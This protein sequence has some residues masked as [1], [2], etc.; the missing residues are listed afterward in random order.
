MKKNISNLFSSTTFMRKIYAFIFLFV[1]A[2]TYIGAKKLYAVTQTQCTGNFPIEIGLNPNTSFSCGGLTISNFVVLNQL[3]EPVSMFITGAS[4]A[5]NKV[6]FTFD[7]VLNNAPFGTDYVFRYKVTG[8][9]SGLGVSMQGENSFIIADACSSE[10]DPVTNYITCTGDYRNRLTTGIGSTPDMPNHQDFYPGNITYYSPIYLF[11]DIAIANFSGTG[12]GTIS[13]FTE[14][15]DV[16]P[17]P[18]PTNKTVKVCLMLENSTGVLATTSAGLPAAAMVTQFATTQDTSL[19]FFISQWSTTQFTPNTSILSNGVN[20]AECVT[21]DRADIDPT[22]YYSPLTIT[23]SGWGTPLYND[24]L[25]SSLNS[26]Q[27]FFPYN[28]DYTNNTYPISNSNG[29]IN[30]SLTNDTRTVVYF[31]PRATT[32]P[33]PVNTPPTITLVGDNPQQFTIGGNFTDLGA[34]AT[35]AQDGNLTSVIIVTSNNVS[36][37]TPGTY[38]ITYRVTDSGGLSAEVTRTVIVSNPTG[39][40][41]SSTG[42]IT[43]CL[44]IGDNQ[45]N[46]ATTSTGLPAGV[47]YVNLGTTTALS[48]SSL[49][50]VTN[51]PAWSAST[52]VPNTKT[53]GNINDSQCFTIPNLSLGT[54]YYSQLYID[55]PVWNTAKLS[56]G[57]N[58]T[59]NNI[60]DLFNYSPELFTATT[61]DDVNRNLNSDGQ[62][63]LTQSNKDQKV[64]FFTTW[65]PIS[66]PAPQCLMPNITS[67]LTINQL[68]G[69]AF[70]YKLTSATSTDVLSVAT[71]TLPSGFTFA[72]STNTITGTTTLGTWNI[73]VNASNTCTTTAKTLVL[74]VTNPQ[75]NGGGG[76][77]GGGGNVPV[78]PPAGNGP[79][80][81]SYGGGNIPV[82]A[83]TIPAATTSTT[84]GSSTGGSTE[85][86][87][88]Y[89]RDYLR[90]DFNNDPVEVKKLQVFLR[91]LEGVTNLQVTGIYDE[92]TVAAVKAFQAKYSSDILSPW[93]DETPTGYTYLLTKKKVNE[94]Y[95]KKAFP[96]TSEQENEVTAFRTFLQNLK[97]AGVNL[98]NNDGGGFGIGGDNSVGVVTPNK[99]KATTTN[100]LNIDGNTNVEGQS[101]F[102]NLIGKLR[103]TTS[104]LANL[105]FATVTG[106]TSV[107]STGQNLVSR[108]LES[109]KGLLGL[110]LSAFAWPF[111]KL[112]SGL[113]L[114]NWFSTGTQCIA[115]WD[116]FNWIL[117]VAILLS[118]YL[119]YREYRKNNK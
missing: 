107:V 1:V 25:N 82:I 66:N 85:N 73:T 24:N 14:T 32:V 8:D 103:G 97:N 15:F 16:R 79:I 61:T 105:S 50:S 65:N 30:L 94:I 96:L 90:A 56:D 109:G 37:T 55:I 27:Q 63:V 47:F 21:F 118:T 5:D 98:G 40:P 44:A 113:T 38:Y 99:T 26:I 41:V 112:F 83:P 23:G 88:Y 93:G 2:F 91:D 43:F 31:V 101:F 53:F 59:I 52:F 110:A 36:T 6:S 116:Y 54:Y 108:I 19:A 117:L 87:C 102:G 20:D 62:I 35:D 119:W 69:E 4:Y 115:G 84:G 77:G 104:Q 17:V 46:I 76:G 58:Q 74:N 45:N 106:T 92:A 114:P 34:T 68:V 29:V 89:L 72:T 67:T 81:G 3:A 51:T 10:L 9:T 18:T 71:S 86:S 42:S 7:P 49:V 12:T 78:N 57:F 13:S 22:Y 11:H 100:V 75:S 48:T 95:C 111:G 60:F 64:V 33:N 70:S 80:V 39:N 28:T